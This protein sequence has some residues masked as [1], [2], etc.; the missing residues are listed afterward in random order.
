MSSC[1]QRESD[2]VMG[3]QFVCVLWDLI[4]KDSKTGATWLLLSYL[5]VVSN[6]VWPHRWQP[7][8]LRRPWDSPGK[9]IG[10]GCHFLLQCMK[11]KSESEVIQSCLTLCNPMDCSLPGSSIHGVFQARVLEWGAI[12]FSRMTQHLGLN[13]LKIHSPTR[14]AAG[15]GGFQTRMANNLLVGL[16]F[17]TSWQP[18]GGWMD[19]LHGNSGL[20]VQVSWYADNT[21]LCW[22]S[23]SGP[24]N[25]T[26]TAFYWLKEARL[27]TKGSEVDSSISEKSAKV[28]SQK[29]RAWRPYFEN[30]V[31][32]GVTMKEEEEEQTHWLTQLWSS[33][34]SEVLFSV[35]IPY[36]LSQF[37]S[38]FLLLASKAFQQKQTAINTP[39]SQECGENCPDSVCVLVKN[40]DIWGGRMWRFSCWVFLGIYRT[41]QG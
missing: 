6:S 5:A 18:Q 34:G 20:Q 31:S 1:Y 30:T 38:L 26:S 27:D 28:T 32:P 29:N 8:R 23:I 16:S 9:N 36:P 13:Y 40:A 2:L 24:G 39:Q 25:I 17:L 35:I 11:V 15:L 19:L 22:P 12:A 41:P 14:L 37:E 4:W 10:V 21:G 7:T 3:S 33:F